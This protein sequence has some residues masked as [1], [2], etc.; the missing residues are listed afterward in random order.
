[1]GDIKGGP[2]FT[3]LAYDDYRILHANL[4][5]HENL[6]TRDRIVP[7]HGVHRPPNSAAPA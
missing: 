2:A 4:I 1:M 7:V 5:K 6:S 3:H